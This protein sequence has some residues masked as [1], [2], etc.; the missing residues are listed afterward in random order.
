MRVELKFK[1]CSGR[2]ATQVSYQVNDNTLVVWR[3][4]T[5]TLANTETG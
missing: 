3:C 5:Y 4:R 1:P 2:G